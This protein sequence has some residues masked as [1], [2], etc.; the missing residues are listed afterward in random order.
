M[1]KK[2][3]PTF[4]SVWAMTRENEL[5][6][7]ETGS[8]LKESIEESKRL[9][10]FLKESIEESKRQDIVLKEY[11]EKSIEESKRQDIVLKEY[12]EKSI[13]ESKR[14]ESILKESIEESKRE[15]NILKESFKESQWRM[16]RFDEHL[17]YFG[18]SLGDVVELLLVPGICGKMN[19]HGH[20]FTRL[21]PN[22]IVNKDN[23]KT[24]TEIDLMLENGEESMAVE[25]KTNL[26]VKWVNRHLGR[27]ELLRKNESITGLKGKVLFGAVAGITID[28]DARDLALENGMYVIGMIEDEEKLE[29]T[30]PKKN[31]IGRW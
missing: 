25:I 10:S 1:P 15:D 7:K 14:L 2:E 19:I 30:A 8:I 24:L 18:R 26:S 12:I 23:G 20:R 6:I 22:K 5:R 11:I 3:K 29:V 17:G 28:E 21:G 4:E 31:K 9:E 16:S 27:L 13:E